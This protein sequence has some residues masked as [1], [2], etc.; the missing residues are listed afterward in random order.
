MAEGGYEF[1][2]PSFDKDDY[3]DDNEETTCINEEPY[4]ISFY[5]R[6]VTLNN[7]IG[8]DREK[9][10]KSLLETMT[11]GIYERNQEAVRKIKHFI[12]SDNLGIPFLC[13]SYG[14][15]DCPLSYYD[16]KGPMAPI[17][18][19]T[20]DTLKNK[21][22]IDFIRRVLG[23]DDFQS[24][25]SRQGH[26]RK[27]FKQLITPE[28]LQ[29]VEKNLP[30][31]DNVEMTNLPNAAETAAGSGKRNV[32]LA[33]EPEAAA[34]SCM[35]LTSQQ[36]EDMN[37]FGDVGQKFLVAD[38]GGGTADLSAVEVLKDGTLKELHQSHGNN[39]GGQN[40]N[41]AFIQHCHESFQGK[42]WKEIFTNITPADAFKMEANFETIKVQ[43]GS[44]DPDSLMMDVAIPNAICDGIEEKSITLKEESIIHYNDREFMFEY[45]FVREKLFYTTCNMIYDTIQK[46]LEH[47][48]TKGIKTVILVGGLSESNMVIEILRKRVEEYFP[49]V[50]VVVP[51]LPFKSVLQGA[52]LY[53]H[54]PMIFSSRI[55]R[56]TYGIAT[57]RVFDEAKHDAS[58]K[59][60]IEITEDF[61]YEGCKKIGIMEVEMPD[62]TGGRDR[63]VE[64]NMLY[65]GTQIAVHAKDVTSGNEVNAEI[66]FG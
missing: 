42:K 26:G 7:Y 48:K 56:E 45:D 66:F 4:Q 11:K 63:D 12:K 6:Y 54:D 39:A 61:W 22:K 38:L 60:R 14:V 36:K 25:T 51:D 5:D 37:N 47:E 32:L 59:W 27:E 23:V 28:D 17:Q 52:V 34:I 29:N 13:V 33:L 3:D 21:Y 53:G 58:K 57:N 18:Y 43:I 35:H 15:K 41:D 64:V 8:S 16:T 1:E 31:V 40:I 24:Y 55:S 49:G 20:L 19:Y 46:V 62:T 44:M 50:K 30:D 65:G 10:E 2:N 9:E